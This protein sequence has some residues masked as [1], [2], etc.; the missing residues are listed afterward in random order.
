VNT[1]GGR[2]DAEFNVDAPVTREIELIFLARFLHAGGRQ[3][4]L[5]ERCPLRYHGNRTSGTSNAYC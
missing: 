2:Y 3:E 5:L 4:R 1:S